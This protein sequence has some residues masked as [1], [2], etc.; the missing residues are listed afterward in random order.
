ML[1]SKTVRLGE[2]GNF[3]LTSH[4]EGS[5]IWKK[6]FRKIKRINL[7]FLATLFVREALQKATFKPVNLST[8]NSVFFTLFVSNRCRTQRFFFA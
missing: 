3:Y 4:S 1:D 5:E 7:R 8:S 2:V 6:Q